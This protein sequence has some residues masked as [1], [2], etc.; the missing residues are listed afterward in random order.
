M[1]LEIV[2]EE[3]CEDSER[4]KQELIEGEVY[5]NYFRYLI[6]QLHII[7]LLICKVFGFSHCFCRILIQDF[8]VID[9][10]QNIS[11][12]PLISGITGF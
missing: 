10:K 12:G 7:I 6:L 1:K 5:F 3:L 8:F 4:I 9:H 11:S 2:K